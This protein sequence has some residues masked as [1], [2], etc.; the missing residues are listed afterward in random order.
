MEEK[1]SPPSANQGL[2]KA[3]PRHSHTVCT[4]PLHLRQTYFSEVT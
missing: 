1:N 4:H 3:E 2:S